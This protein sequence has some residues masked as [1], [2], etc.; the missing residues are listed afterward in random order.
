[1]NA[2]PNARSFLV[3]VLPP[4]EGAQPGDRVRATADII[5][6]DRARGGPAKRQGDFVSDNTSCSLAMLINSQVVYNRTLVITGDAGD[7]IVSDEAPLSK[8]VKLEIIQTCQLGREATLVIYNIALELVKGTPSTTTTHVT[9]TTTSRP[10]P[11]GFPERSGR[12]QFLGCAESSE[13]YPTFFLADES[14]RMTID[15]CT[16]AC[17]GWDYAGVHD[18]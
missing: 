2:T 17:R 6:S 8:N 5:V 14:N 9:T 10:A 16:H 18:T 12:F 15:R 11:T 4:P 3:G 13:N 7:R 1:M